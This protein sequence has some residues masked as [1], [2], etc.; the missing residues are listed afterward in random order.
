M[1]NV[2]ESIFEKIYEFCM[3]KRQQIKISRISMIKIVKFLKKYHIDIKNSLF[4]FVHENKIFVVV[5]ND[6]KKYIEIF[7]RKRK[8]EI[9]EIIID[10]HIRMKF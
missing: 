10:F 2:I 9:F 7:F 1:K 5:K 3:K 4:I 8:F 6:F